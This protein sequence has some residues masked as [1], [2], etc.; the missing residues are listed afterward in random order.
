MVKFWPST[1]FWARSMARV[2]IVCSMGTPS[3]MPM[4]AMRPEMPLAAEDPHQVVL[5]GQVEAR[6]ARV[7]LAAGAAAELVVDAAGLVA[8]GADDV[9][10]AEGDDLLVLLLR[11]LRRLGQGL[12][13]AARA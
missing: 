4:R 12:L 13:A 5:E 3:L 1:C 11:D 8:L 7:A 6:R 2:T 9:Q 10:A